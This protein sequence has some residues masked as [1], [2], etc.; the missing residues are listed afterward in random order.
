MQTFTLPVSDCGLF[1]GGEIGPDVFDTQPK[2]VP[3]YGVI[4]WYESKELAKAALL[5][6]IETWPPPAQPEIEP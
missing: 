5:A 6:L 4:V 2:P 3:R 1:A